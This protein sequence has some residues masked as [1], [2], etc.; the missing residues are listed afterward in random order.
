MPNI[1]HSQNSRDYCPDSFFLS[2]T[3][4]EKVEAIIKALKTEKATLSGDIDIKFIKLACP[5]IS[6]MI[7]GLFTLCVKKGVFPDDM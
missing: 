1:N 5:I 2:P 6:P 4:S 7:S 3:N